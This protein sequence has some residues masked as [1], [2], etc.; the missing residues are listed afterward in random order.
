MK[1]DRLCEIVITE[2]LGDLFFV[3]ENPQYVKLIDADLIGKLQSIAG[4][5]SLKEMKPL[6]AYTFL[7][8]LIEHL[9]DNGSFND[10]SGKIIYTGNGTTIEGILTSIQ[11]YI[12][13]KLRD[14][15]EEAGS[16]LTT[17]KIQRA[18]DKIR[19]F[20]SSKIVNTKNGFKS[21]LKDIQSHQL[22][23]EQEEQETLDRLAKD[24][25]SGEDAL[26]GKKQKTLKPTDIEDLTGGFGPE[27]PEYD[28]DI[29]G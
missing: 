12:S 24:I 25:E 2:K 21:L 22:D 3:Q 26:L 18:A 23:K 27:K 20:L 29:F 28:P 15:E 5:K 1:F 10:E 7:E 17:G 11:V 16:S 4:I 6:E 14:K 8:G 9:Q 13:D 19:K